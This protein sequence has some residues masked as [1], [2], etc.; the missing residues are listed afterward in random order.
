MQSWLERARATA[1]KRAIKRGSSDL[2]TLED[3]GEYGDYLRGLL[4]EDPSLGYRRL[5]EA[6]KAKGVVVSQKTMQNWLAR[7]HGKSSRTVLPKPREELPEL[8]L[9]G[10]RRYQDIL[11]CQADSDTDQTYV[12]LRAWL[13]ATFHVTCNKN[14]MMH[15]YQ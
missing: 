1:P 15:W 5:R 7:Y 2:P 6:I 4:A 9:N 3:L 11:L 12:Q 8:D 14:T 10:V 13:E